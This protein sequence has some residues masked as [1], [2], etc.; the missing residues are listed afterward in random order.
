VEGHTVAVAQEWFDRFSGGDDNPN[1]NKICGQKIKISKN[2][3]DEY[4][5]ITDICPRKCRSQ[6]TMRIC[7]DVYSFQPALWEVST[8]LRVYLSRSRTWT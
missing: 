4:A 6:R 8:C 7:A 1:N 3:K 5:T 2:G